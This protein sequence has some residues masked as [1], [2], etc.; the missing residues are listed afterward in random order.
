M[1]SERHRRLWRRRWRRRPLLPFLLAATIAIDLVLATVRTESPYA[2]GFVGAQISLLGVWVTWAP[3]RL[4]ARACVALAAVLAG[5]AY[6]GGL[7]TGAPP[8]PIEVG[9]TPVIIDLRPIVTTVVLAS[10]V[11]AVV[12]AAV[13]RLLARS[14]RRGVGGPI[15]PRIG[16]GLLISLT[17]LTAVAIGFGRQTDWDVLTLSMVGALITLE[18]MVVA[19]VLALSLAIP[20]P[21]WRLLVLGGVPVTAIVAIAAADGPHLATYFATHA[22][23]LGGWLL[24]IDARWRPSPNP[25]DAEPPLAGPKL[26]TEA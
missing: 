24:S 12:A 23:V 4:V 9:P 2:T 25:A 6:S 26:Y 19:T 1:S 20:N 17:T 7:A 21:V 16:L 14:M 3:R 8:E 15:R 5:L 11:T 13:V 18:G 22:A 10:L